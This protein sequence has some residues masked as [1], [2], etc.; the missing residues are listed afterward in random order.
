MIMS[1]NAITILLVLTIM[2]ELTVSDHALVTI[3]KTVKH[4]VVE[5]VGDD[6]IDYNFYREL[7]KLSIE[8]LSINIQSEDIKHSIDWNGLNE[9]LANIPSTV[10]K[11]SLYCNTKFLGELIDLS[12]VAGKFEEFEFDLTESVEKWAGYTYYSMVKCA[13]IGI[14]NTAR[15]LSNNPITCDTGTTLINPDT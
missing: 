11:F 3:P 9:I 15:F 2:E 5:S 4:L 7:R 1:C 14:P 6:E 10:T 13:I 12:R 8:Q